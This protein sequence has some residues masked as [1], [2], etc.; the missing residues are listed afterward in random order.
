MKLGRIVLFKGAG[1]YDALRIFTD[2]LASAFNELARETV[3]VDFEN[4]NYSS[5]LKEA[6][7]QE[8]DF[9][10]SF[11]GVCCDLNIDGKLFL[12]SVS[13]PVIFGLVD[14]PIHHLDILHLG[15]ERLLVS[16]VDR[17]AIDFINK[18][19]PYAGIKGST[20]SPHV[21]IAEDKYTPR[22]DI[23][24]RMIPVLFCGSYYNPNDIFKSQIA[25]LPDH[26][27]Q[28]LKGVI[29][30]AIT[31]P[32]EALPKVAEE[33]LHS[34]NLHY[35]YSFWIN[36]F[37]FLKIGDAYIR[38]VRRTE[39]IQNLLEAGISVVVAG[40]GWERFPLA[41]KLVVQKARSLQD[42]I[43][44]M[45]QA[46]ICLD[47]GANF[48]YGGHERT[49]TAMKSGVPVVASF[50]R[51]YQENFIDGEE[52]ALYSSVD[53]NELPDKIGGLLTNVSR[54]EQISAR[55][56]QVVLEKHTYK[57][58]AERLLKFVD[59]YKA[60]KKVAKYSL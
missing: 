35:D 6:F 53:K 33:F 49:F 24:K 38:A 50:N 15:L 37:S 41:D 45:K 29:D 10:F 58:Y 23:Q 26:V 13:S 47:I 39:D 52:I 19:L 20:F 4:V 14:H 43:A 12:N 5:Q 30:I 40:D 57:Q 3:V 17:E 28:L 42:A 32:G 48:A 9:V 44:L 25:S 55:A 56:Y 51:Y 31:K 59:T 22:I 11:N 46:K 2:Q 21:A 34:E 7:S 27:S 1:I 36:F 18:S 54:L 16:C 8:C 60:M